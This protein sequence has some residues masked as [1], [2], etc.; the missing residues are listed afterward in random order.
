M[1]YGNLADGSP[2]EIFTLRTAAIE[3]SFIT[4]GARI[5]RLKTHAACGKFEDIV[6]GCESLSGY[7][8]D[9]NYLG[10]IAG[11]YA[12]RIAHGFFELGGRQH[13]VATNEGENCLHGGFTGFDRRVWSANLNGN[14][15]T[16]CYTSPSGEE[17]FPG[18]LQTTV[19]YTLWGN[20]LRIQYRAAADAPTVLNLT[21][22]SYFNLSGN[23]ATRIEDHEVAI[24]STSFTPVTRQLIPTGNIE[25]VAGT[26]MDFRRST[27]IG[28]RIDESYA[29]LT[30]AGGYDHNWVL[31][32]QQKDRWRRAAQ[33][34]EPT[35]KRVMEVFTSEPG[36]QF[37][38]GNFLDGS[39]PGKQGRHIEYRTGLCLE[40]QHFPDSPNHPQFP[41]T[42]VSP[43][44]AF[45]SST[46]YRFSSQDQ[47][48]QD[49]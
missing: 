23:H 49:R 45:T 37:Y 5:V 3:A 16:F 13:Q 43:E 36:L 48:G 34:F 33:V 42:V 4:Y 26:P 47:A 30:F 7:E 35:S 12:N 6:L 9:K 21:N 18:T 41:S 2:V 46:V 1:H 32:E 20:E 39:T 19:R 8:N 28:V 44:R 38:S 40:T 17:G 14:S 10:S 29:Q 24:F 22:H 27:A 11:R 31:E 15:L 25:S